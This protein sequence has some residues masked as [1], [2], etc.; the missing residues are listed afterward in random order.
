VNIK[1]YLISFFIL[2][3]FSCFFM[4]SFS[5]LTNENVP[6]IK[7]HDLSFY[8]LSKDD[9]DK[10]ISK[11]VNFKNFHRKL[12]SSNLYQDMPW[13]FLPP[14][15]YI[16]NMEAENE[17][18]LNKRK[19]YVSKNKMRWLSNNLVS[20]SV[21]DEQNVF[22]AFYNFRPEKGEFNP[23]YFR[24]GGAW[25]YPVALTLYLSSE[26]KAFQLN[27]DISNYLNN[28]QDIQKIS[29]ISKT[30]GIISCI[31]G[32][33]VIFFLVRRFF[34]LQTAV[35]SFMLTI[36]CPI[37]IVETIYLKP[38][39][40]SFM[41]YS[42]AFYFIYKFVFDYTR[43]IFNLI[44]ASVF[45]G[46][47]AGSVISSGS[48][49]FVL[50][51]AII[52]KNNGSKNENNKRNY[53]LGIIFRYFAISFVI[54]LVIFFVSNPYSI[55]S[56]DQ[57]TKE[58]SF[59]LN[60]LSTYSFFDLSAHLRNVKSLLEGLGYSL[61][62]TCLLAT[63]WVIL[64]HLDRRIQ[65]VLAAIFSYYFFTFNVC[66]A[67]DTIH[68]LVP[69]V[70]LMAIIPGFAF[71]KFIHRYKHKILIYLFVIVIFLGS[72]INSFFYYK[73]FQNK[74]RILSGEW[75]N[76]NIPKGSSVG[77]YIDNSGLSYAYPYY[78]FFLYKFVNDD[79]FNLRNIKKAKPDYIIRAE[80]YHPKVFTYPEEE[81]AS[82]LNKHIDLNTKGTRFRWKINIDEEKNLPLDYQEIARFDSKVGKLDLVFSNNL[83]S[84]W[85]NEIVIYKKNK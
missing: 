56:F 23:K 17:L 28:P 51:F 67:E 47:A 69:I 37:L 73:L 44:L 79:S 20:P 8:S 34:N 6:N 5:G 42:I 18:F 15:G 38:L 58:I 62:I 25:L 53:C 48:I 41:W 82:Q 71:D 66:F 40:T 26:C 2:F 19:M 52:L 39:L 65:L 70:P 10:L 74:P 13:Q 29:I 81:I 24:Y 55:I 57:F 14:E 78:N 83:A 54:S 22:R 30:F 11:M 63:S 43:S 4:M 75:I 77:T 59:N 7:I 80:T 64:K 76:K 68:G 9:K 32:I 31:F 33:L 27:K 85:T 36:F 3:L 1:N 46:L 60:K 16:K 50:F 45:V 12:V 61:G 72:F 49:I 21:W 35:I 84:W